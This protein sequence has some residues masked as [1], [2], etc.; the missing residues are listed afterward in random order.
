MKVVIAHNLYSSAQPSGENTIVAS[1]SELLTAAG[2]R[3]LPLLRSS[4]E[5]GRL[6]LPGKALLPVSPIY[7]SA[8]QRQLSE[9]IRRDRPDVLHLHNPYPLLSPWVVRTAH[10]H[11]VPVVQTV[12][13]YR[14]VCVD[15]TYFRD[16]QP[17]HDCLGKAFPYPAVQH[18][19]YR[20]SRAQS[21]VMATTLA[22]HRST[23]QSVDRFIALAPHI[24]EHLSSFGIPDEKI[25][26]KPNPVP[27]P[28][29]HSERGDG[30]LFL[31]RLIEAKGVGLLLDAWGRHPDG[32]L[33]T[34]RIVG[35]GPLRDRVEQAAASRADIEYLGLLDHQAALAAVRA[36]AV[37]VVPSTYA[38]ALPTVILEALSNA[39]PVL[40]T[41][42]G[43]TPYLLGT[44]PDHEPAD[45]PPGWVVPPEPAALDEA[46]GVARVRAAALAKVARA[47]Y[48]T[49]FSPDVLLRRL[50]DVYT[51]VAADAR[52][53][54]A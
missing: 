15:S 35:D 19:C 42:V 54:T 34:L 39:R 25:T 28:G 6:S 1:D 3:V 2:V 51:E 14:H 7:A 21:L 29:P 17:C 45:T 16:G 24:A 41:A 18:A 5:I 31:G 20:G 40:G 48:E 23:W 10:K 36:A 52:T 53:A 8:A 33:G 47:R 32:E 11:G 9:L 49:V 30:F 4:D 46:F 12:H 22:V 44:D 38:D 13:N 27:D 50:I 37:V 43:G 26:V